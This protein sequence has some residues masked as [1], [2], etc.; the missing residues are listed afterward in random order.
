MD[1]FKR[2]ENDEKQID[3][4]E[5]EKDFA[6]GNSEKANSDR[7]QADKTLSMLSSIKCTL[8]IFLLILS[9]TI[10]MALMG[11]RQT[12]ISQ[13]LH[14]A[15]TIG[16]FWFVIFWMAAMEGCQ[17]SLVGLAPVPKSKYVS[18]HPTAF[19]ITSFIHKDANLERFIVGRQ[20]LVVLAVFV[21]NLAAGSATGDAKVLGLPNIMNAIFV[22]SGIAPV[23]IAVMVGQLMAQVNATRSMLDTI[24]NRFVLYFV[25][26]ASMVIEMSGL[27]HAT[28]LV[29]I[30][31]AKLTGKIDLPDEPKLVRKISFW[32]RVAFSLAI[33]V[34]SF[35]LVLVALFAGKTTMWKGV[36]PVIS[37][38][39]FFLLMTFAGIMEGMQI[40]ILAVAKLPN[41]ALTK[42]S[43][44]KKNCELVFR[45]ENLQAFLIGRQILV[46]ACMFVLARITGM[47][48]TSVQGDNI[49][50]V[51]DA[52][53]ERLFNSNI[54]A[55]IV[56]TI[57]S[58]LVWRVAASTSPIAFLSNP[59]IS[60]IIRCCLIIEASGLCSAASLLARVQSKICKF[61]SDEEY[62]GDP[63]EVTETKLDLVLQPMEDS[64]ELDTESAHSA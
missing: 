60:V 1:C 15:A 45:G 36:P 32:L 64:R 14:P 43:V 16:I 9:I 8:S 19:K 20:F 5:V 2:C 41:E 50:G 49:F 11:T 57:A 61:K 4:I 58:S 25:A 28:Y 26:Y 12:Q 54:F 33:L 24:N 46:T 17:P 34:F 37:V 42:H 48:G 39:L 51:P 52:V 44:A 29:Q 7:Q 10:A 13:S 47:D 63:Q 53:Q 40:A 27:L 18:S 31:Y 35:T 6:M 22:N 23:L 21:T 30:L 3:D 59:T 56:T 55:A 62:I 38:I